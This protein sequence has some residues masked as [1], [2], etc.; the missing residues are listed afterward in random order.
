MHLADGMPPS[1]GNHAFDSPASLSDD[2][3]A[4]STTADMDGIRGKALPMNTRVRVRETGL[5]QS[6]R[7]W[8]RCGSTPSRM[9]RTCCMLPLLD[10]ATRLALSKVT[11]PGLSLSV[12]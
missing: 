2:M 4:D 3:P 11:V 12:C 8:L 5:S 1:Q 9:A 6:E 10:K 7:A